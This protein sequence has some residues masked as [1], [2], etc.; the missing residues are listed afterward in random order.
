MDGSGL[1]CS[2]VACVNR[3]KSQAVISAITQWNEFCWQDAPNYRD[4]PRD[5]GAEPVLV[6]RAF[7]FLDG[8]TRAELA[9]G[10]RRAIYPVR[11]TISFATRRTPLPSR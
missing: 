2:F 7:R 1:V 10:T 9:S 8:A 3:A 6:R 11:T 4:A 5:P